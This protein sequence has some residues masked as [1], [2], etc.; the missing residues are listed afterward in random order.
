MSEVE[1]PVGGGRPSANKTG[2]ALAAVVIVALAAFGWQSFS[3]SL[4]SYTHDY[5]E[6]QRR[7]G[8]LLQVP[9]VLD[10]SER[11]K[12]L[13][14]TGGFEFTMLDVTSRTAKLRVRYLGVKPSNFDQ[15]TQV[16]CVGRYKDG[17]FLAEQLL[18]KCPSKEQQKLKGESG[19]TP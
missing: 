1:R 9:G 5:A 10:R 7:A 2:Y 19:S 4:A 3:K 16:V 8:E 11:E 15:A 13:T 14:Q 17:V 6:V 12:S 18:V